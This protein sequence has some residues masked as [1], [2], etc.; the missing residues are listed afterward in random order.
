MPAN[1]PIQ[2][3]YLITGLQYGGAN[4][5]MVRLLDGLDPEQYDITVIS[6]VETS[7]DIV[8]LL[9][10]SATL[11][12]LHIS[13]PT[14]I[15][16]V[17]KLFQLLRGTDV[18][19]CS[20]FHA[21][22]VG[23]PIGRLLRIPRVL[24]WQHNTSYR[25]PTRRKIYSQLYNLAHHI[26]ADSESVTEMLVAK[27]DI[28]GTNISQLPIAG[29]DTHRFSPRRRENNN[30]PI[31]SIGT[32][33]RLV[34]QKGLFDLLRCAEVLGDQYQFKII[35]QGEQRD[36]LEQSAPDNVSLLGSVPDA[37]LPEYLQ[38]FDVYFQ[39]SKHEG[40][41]MTVIEAMACGLPVV[42]SS[43]G[44]IT[45]SVVPGETGYL[46]EAGN[47]DC[48]CDRLQQLRSAP[49]LRSEMGTA[50]RQRVQSQYSQAVLVD[51]FEQVLIKTKT[52]N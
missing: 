51:R 27:F 36:E 39:P 43:V 23:V 40:L 10:E 35:G 18:L 49:D 7:D 5:G 44:G 20:L 34:E 29:V 2:L 11:H 13:Q 52:D 47:I 15:H 14:E 12:R 25:T 32:I 22:V 50:G 16:R 31:I 9:P 45:E 41:C 26:L 8:S 6:V 19:M 17:L 48:F 28:S 3:T 42:A 33:A 1:D 4:I 37:D 38:N 46:C 21:S 24:I 30:K